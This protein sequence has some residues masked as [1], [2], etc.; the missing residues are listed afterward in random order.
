MYLLSGGVRPV[1][2]LHWVAEITDL[3]QH[4]LHD[5]GAKPWGVH[6][7]CWHALAPGDDHLT[8]RVGQRKDGYM[9]LFLGLVDRSGCGVTCQP[10]SYVLVNGTKY[11]KPKHRECWRAENTLHLG[12]IETVDVRGSSCEHIRTYV[13]ESITT[14]CR[15]LWPCRPLLTAYKTCMQL[16]KAYMAKAFTNQLLLILLHTYLLTIN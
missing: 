11:W 9:H 1:V 7:L 6:H 14:D 15:T 8:C 12:T 13:T 10:G 3:L 4:C 2:P 5:G 16:T